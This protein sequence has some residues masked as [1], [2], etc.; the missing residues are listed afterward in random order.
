MVQSILQLKSRQTAEE[1][2]LVLSGELDMAGAPELG[3]ALARAQSDGHQV[4]V[5]LSSLTFIDSTGLRTLLEAARRG[6]LTDRRLQVVEGPPQVQRIFQLTHTA[7]HFD[8]MPPS[9]AG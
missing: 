5:D 6:S 1:H 7:D 9:R 2:W 8:W 3:A 4:V